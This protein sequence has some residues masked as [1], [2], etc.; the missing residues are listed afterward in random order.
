MGS[1]TGY[2]LIA[3]DVIEAAAPKRAWWA[4]GK[5]AASRRKVF[6]LFLVGFCVTP[7]YVVWT[8]WEPI[9][10]LVLATVL[11]AAVLPLVTLVLLRLTADRR[12]MKE[13]A[14]RWYSNLGLAV[15]VVTSI[16]AS[17]RTAME[18]LER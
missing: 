18:L 12:I 14:N 11:L 16:Y 17:F 3:A 9:P 1:N 6:R 7:I 8:D 4:E 5:P 2:S 13:H 15:V 10:I